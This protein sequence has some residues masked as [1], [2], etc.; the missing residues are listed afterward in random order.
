MF[1]T[2]EIEEDIE[3]ELSGIFRVKLVAKTIVLGPPGTHF[4]HMKVKAINY[5]GNF[6]NAFS[7]FN[8]FFNNRV[9]VFALNF[10]PTSYFKI[11]NAPGNI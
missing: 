3:S 9:W 6:R 2:M 7:F 10:A 1:S 11:S 5:Q 4:L 8:H